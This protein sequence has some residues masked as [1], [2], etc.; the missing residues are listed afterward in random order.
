MPIVQAL[1][2]AGATVT[3]DS[4]WALQAAAEQGHLAAVKLLLDYGADI[5]HFSVQHS[6]GTA[7]QAACDCG[8]EEVVE[9]LLSKGADPNKGGGRYE[10]PIIVASMQPKI[11]PHLLAAPGIELNVVGGPGHGSPLVYAAASLP[12]EYIVQLIQ[13]GADVNMVDLDGDTPLMAAAL[14]GD[15]ECVKLLLEH[16]ADIMTISPNRGTA[17]EVALE[18][19]HDECIKLLANRAVFIQ[20]QLQISAEREEWLALEIIEQERENRRYLHQQQQQQQ[21]HQ[22]RQQQQR[23]GSDFGQQEPELEDQIGRLRLQDDDHDVDVDSLSQGGDGNPH[24]TTGEEE[25]SYQQGSW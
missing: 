3:S 16:G 5:N 11:L 8:N 23:I 1:L 22:Q 9:Y 10:Y 21:Q 7:L 25:D 2:E 19:G 17:L 13:A 14:V 20:R 12:A 4:G 6:S 15:Y 24:P 18:E